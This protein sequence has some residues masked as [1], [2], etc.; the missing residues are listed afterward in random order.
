M[1]LG[2]SLKRFRKTFRLSQKEVAK[3]GN[4]TYQSYQTYE[5]DKS[6]PSVAVIMRIADAYNV[7]TDY[8]LGR[9]D[10]P[11][12]M[13]FDEKEVREAFRIR[14]LWKQLQ[15]VSPQATA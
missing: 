5:Y 2:E 15:A 6:F 13:N 1:T 12:P 4:V 7:S 14:D 8:L 9:S 3:A 10:M 11:Q